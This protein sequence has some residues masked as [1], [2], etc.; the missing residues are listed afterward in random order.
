MRDVKTDSPRRIYK[1][2]IERIQKHIGEKVKYSDGGRKL[3]KQD[4]NKFLELLLDTYE[5]LQNAQVHYC[6]EVFEDK[7]EALGNAILQ[8]KGKREN[9]K[10]TV[11]VIIMENKD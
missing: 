5:N 10:Q 9:I 1:T 6:N 7:S 8:A 11:A 4:F 2:T 3:I